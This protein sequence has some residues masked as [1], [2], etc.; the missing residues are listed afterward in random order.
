MIYAFGLAAFCI[1]WL[2]PGHY[3]PWTGFQQEL[4]AAIGALLIG[5]AATASTGQ[6]RLKVPLI[7]AAAIAFAAVP[8][9]QWLA[10]RVPF[11]ADA[12]LP[13]LYLAGFGMTIIAARAL[14]AVPDQRFAA[15]LFAAVLVAGLVSLG[16]GLGQWLQVGWLSYIE[17]LDRGARVF[18][19]FTQPNHLASM[20][21]L[22]VVAALWLFEMRRIGRIGISILIIAF[23][24]GLVMTQSRVGW[25]FAAVLA[26]WWVLARSRA[27]LRTTGF[28]IAVGLACFIAFTVA[29][30]PINQA[31][32]IPTATV[33]SDRVQQVGGRSIH[34][35]MLWDAVWREPCFG[36]G[37]MQVSAAQQQVAL[38][39]PRSH[40]WVTYSHDLVLDL[41]IWNGVIL[42]TLVCVALTWWIV[43]RCLR[44]RDATTWC[45]M[46]AG[47]VVLAHALVEFPHAYTYFL[48]P[49]GAF[50]GIIEARVVA[51]TSE[52][53]IVNVHA[54]V[55]ALGLAALGAM[56][57]W[58]AVE[59]G[60][61]EDAARRARFKEAGYVTRGD[62]PTVPDVVLLD[63]QREFIWFRLTP[64]RPG[65]GEDDLERMRRVNQRFM[66]PAVMLRYAM[67]AG[68]NGKPEAA[69]RNLEL[70]C[71]LWNRQ[72]CEEGRESWAAAQV[73]YPQLAGI[74][75]PAAVEQNR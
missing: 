71:H 39:H 50:L 69:R 10:G 4:A 6:R 33:L 57:A 62:E 61:V 18:A 47:G 23:V 25:L 29:W 63:N 67:A 48:L 2:L 28:G 58:I 45:A 64:A 3:F 7:A 51:P 15:G 65:M 46:A 13:S 59:Y 9:L 68:L 55:Y 42:G 19:N 54:A 1:A 27:G 30:S 21:G 26:L 38:D 5:L 73:K 17:Q 43:S 35:R 34:W 24:F 52:A 32:D 11:L 37:W 14:A 40:E 70:I 72:R 74:Q 75:F 20:F 8:M 66:P 56:T 16:I 53:R 31:L 49:L 44:C 36:W 60:E 41:L 22:A 12:L